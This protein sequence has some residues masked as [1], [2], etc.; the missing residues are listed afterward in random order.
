[1]ELGVSS[2]VLLVPVPFIPA[3]VSL[4]SLLVC[5]QVN[6]YA[7][8][9]QNCSVHGCDDSMTISGRG[10]LAKDHMCHFAIC[11]SLLTRDNAQLE[12][13]LCMSIY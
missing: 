10:E 2:T 3:V 12:E 8:V 1:M 7:A 13:E 4:T 6:T 9:W 5:W 11:G